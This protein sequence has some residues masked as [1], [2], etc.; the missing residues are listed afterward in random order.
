M[1]LARTSESLSF[2]ALP[3]WGDRAST[4]LS[5]KHDF[6]EARQVA[7]KATPLVLRQAQDDSTFAG[8]HGTVN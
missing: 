4:S 3:E 6:V 7:G 2:Q 5:T 8:V 1:R